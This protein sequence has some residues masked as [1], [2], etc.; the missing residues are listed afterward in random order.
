MESELVLSVKKNVTCGFIKV[1]IRHCVTFFNGIA[2]H[3]EGA[4]TQ[5]PMKKAQSG[6]EKLELG[7]ERC[8]HVSIAKEL[9]LLRSFSFLRAVV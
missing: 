3:S 4:A 9:K 6:T 8:S 5:C 2:D 1:S 7:G